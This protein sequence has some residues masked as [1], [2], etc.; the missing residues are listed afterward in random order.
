M[1]TLLGA[2]LQPNGIESSMT[3]TLVRLEWSQ[4]AAMA[5][6]GLERRADEEVNSEN[7]DLFLCRRRR[8][9]DINSCIIIIVIEPSS[10]WCL[11]DLAGFSSLTV[12]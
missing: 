5:P 2:Y 1:A 4:A 9:R 7:I 11:A 3:T 10:R 6:I 8:R 12:V